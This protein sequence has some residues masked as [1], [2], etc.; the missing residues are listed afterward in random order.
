MRSGGHSEM[1]NAFVVLNSDVKIRM[2][3]SCAVVFEKM[4]KTK[5]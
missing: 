1:I 2:V 4:S 5:S 3:E